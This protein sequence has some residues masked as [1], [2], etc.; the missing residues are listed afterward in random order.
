MIPNVLTIAGSDPSG[1]AGIQADIKTLSALGA[2]SAAVITAL[3]A[4]NTRGVTAVHP[5]SSRI[6]A[7]QLDAVF[8][9]LQIDAVKIGMLANVEIIC[10][11]A[12]AIERYQPKYIVLDTVILSSNGHLLLE[13]DSLSVLRERLLPLASIITPNLY[14]SAVLLD[15]PIAE[16]EAQ[17]ASQGDALQALGVYAVLLK[18]GHLS[19]LCS[20]DWLIEDFCH[21]RLVTNR[22]SVAGTHGTGC[23]LS[24]A[25]AALRPQRLNWVTTV[26]DAKIYLTQALMHSTRISV[27]HGTGPLHHCY[28]WW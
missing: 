15:Q 11:V 21:T 12:A 20:P 23:T 16:N 19:G 7:E 18:G 13:P 2:Y 1:G 10:T 3:T 27:G 4:Q 25:M 6:V 24:S 26:C 5:I 8:S 9:D 14:E 28:S 22:V 17:M